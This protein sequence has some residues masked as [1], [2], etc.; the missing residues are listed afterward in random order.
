[1][2]NSLPCPPCYSC[3]SSALVNQKPTSPQMDAVKEL[4]STLI[5]K[6]VAIDSLAARVVHGPGSN[7]RPSRERPS[8]GRV[9]GRHWIRREGAQEAKRV[10]CW[11]MVPP[12]LYQLLDI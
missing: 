11:G 9:N 5:R 1:M 4:L 12:S 3:T 7:D 10:L 8:S 6:A 2:Y